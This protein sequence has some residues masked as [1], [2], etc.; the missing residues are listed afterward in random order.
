MAQ[1]PDGRSEL[2][3]GNGYSKVLAPCGRVLVSVGSCQEGM[4]VFYNNRP[5]LYGTCKIEGTNI[6]C[7]KGTPPGAASPVNPCPVS[8]SYSTT[9][10]TAAASNK[11]IIPAV[12]YSRNGNDFSSYYHRVAQPQ[13]QPH[14][15]P[16]QTCNTAH[17]VMPNGIGGSRNSGSNEAEQQAAKMGEFLVKQEAGILL[18][19][20]AEELGAA[21]AEYLGAD[22][23]LKES[24]K[25]GQLI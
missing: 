9:T 7:I 14:T 3:A 4:S 5:D 12:F 17:S 18:G 1:L 15:N 19:I 13:L 11:I 21:L 6:V 16:K 20:P 2:L 10:T 25:V 23:I 22:F 24:I 8:F